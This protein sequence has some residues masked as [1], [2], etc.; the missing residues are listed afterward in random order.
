[1][2]PDLPPGTRI[3]RFVVEGTIGRGTSATVY[4]V[5]HEE[6]QTLHALKLLDLDDPQM[7][8]RMLQEGR[9]QAVLRHPN[10]VPVTDVLSVDGRPALLGE[11]V[12]GQSLRTRLGAG[13]LPL[14]E[15]ER[16][17][18]GI[19]A[20]MH[21]AHG[22]GIVHRNLKPENV[23]LDPSA[24]LTVPRITDFGLA[25]YLADPRRTRTGEILGTPH[26]MAPEQARGLTFVDHR[27][28]IFSLGAMLY[29]LVCGVRPFPA[30]DAYTAIQAAAAGAYV[31]PA[32]LCRELPERVQ[33]AIRGSLQPDPDNRLDSCADLLAVLEGSPPLRPA[34]PV[35]KAPDAAAGTALRS[36]APAEDAV[37]AAGTANATAIVVDERG[38]GHCLAV[39]VRLDT[40][41]PGVWN[42]QPVTEDCRASAELALAAALDATA[43]SRGVT[44]QVRAQG[45]RLDG[46]SL[47]LALAIAGIA[48][49]RG[50]KVPG[51]W[52]FTGAVDLDGRIS[53]VGGLPAKIEA[54]VRG[55]IGHFAI[56]ASS[57]PPTVAGVEILP[58]PTV[59]AAVARV[60]AE[61]ARVAKRGTWEAARTR[62]GHGL[63]AVGSAVDRYVV[64][65]LLGDSGGSMV[66][67]VRHRTLG[68]AHALKVLATHSDR[69]KDRLIAEGRVQASLAHPNIVGVT[70][71]VDVHGWPG[72]VMQLV[73]GPS[74]AELLSAQR[75]DLPE[76]ERLFAGILDAVEVAH[77]AG[78][79]HRDLKPSNILLAPSVRGFVPRVADFGLARAISNDP[80]LR[81]TRSGAGMGTPNYMAPEQIRDAKHVDHRADVFALGCILHELVTGALT[82]DGACDIDIFDAIVAERY[83]PPTDAVPGLPARVDRAIRGA[84]TAD[85]TKRIPDCETLRRVLNDRATEGIAGM[86]EVP[87]RVVR[88]G[89]WGVAILAVV[90]AATVGLWVW[91]TR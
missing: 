70:D 38:Q 31:D 73:E 76:A 2:E 89:G 87:P 22:E 69:V 44:W 9:L 75:I 1:M 53:R 27:A 16:I 41:R 60:F 59:S 40:G 36:L 83:R 47:G 12:P 7:R 21:H 81:A 74:L 62:N 6:L 46:P 51:G 3:D 29:E 35:P 71:L 78:V 17:F 25:K 15:A 66:Y 58:V 79:V 10:L 4:R 72:L 52:A 49:T 90:A 55:G 28:D 30:R 37:R 67:K 85:R 34:H 43:I 63:L 18:L 32:V 54:A 5:R 11:F 24:P 84:L 61:S 68:S 23:L 88:R 8:A 56:P 86:G 48:A 64:E 57:A 45:V 14:R 65:G 33:Q 80:G 42:P 13:R 91:A 50:V 82:F 19:V 77:A 26:Y 20:G 39:L